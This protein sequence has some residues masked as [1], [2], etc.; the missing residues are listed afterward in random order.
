MVLQTYNPEHYAVI[1]AQKQSYLDF[2]SQE[3]K[4]REAFEYPPF[5]KMIL[6][7]I[8][9]ENEADVIDIANKLGEIFKMKDFDYLG[10]NPSPIAK[11]QKKYRWQMVFKVNEIA[12]D[13]F[14]KI[15]EADIQ[16]I[17][18]SGKRKG[19]ILIVDVDPNTVL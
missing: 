15:Y 13:N 9:G 17:K 14:E 6:V 16:K 18:I 10:P 19:V 3:I 1:S 4:I 8:S 7:Q 2:Y 12:F 11:I 5:S